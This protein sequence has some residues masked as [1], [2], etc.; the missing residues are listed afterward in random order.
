MAAYFENYAENADIYSR[1]KLRSFLFIKKGYTCSK[2][3]PLK[4]L[5]KMKQGQVVNGHN[6]YIELNAL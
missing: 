3:R 6:T 2:H 4:S 5:Q 1:R